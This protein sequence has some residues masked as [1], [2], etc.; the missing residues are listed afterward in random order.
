MKRVA[1]LL[2]ALFAGC[3]TPKQPVAPARAP[4]VDAVVGGVVST[5]T[6]SNMAMAIAV[7]EKKQETAQY[8]EIIENGFIDAAKEKTTTFSIDVDGAS[9]ANVRRF[10]SANL[11]PPPNAVRIEEMVNYFTYS[12]PQPADGRPLA[13]A[14]EVAGCPWEPSHRVVRIGIQGK[15]IDPWKLAPNNLVFLLD[16]S[17][18]MSPPQRLPLL[19]SAFR[20][21]VDQLRPEDTVSIVVY[22]GAAG[23]VLP[24]T[25]GSEKQTID[26]S[27][28]HLHAG[29]STAGGAGI[30][31]AYQTAEEH[32]SSSANNRVILATDGDFNVGVTD[33]KQLTN[34]IE[35]KRRK[36]I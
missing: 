17:G 5:K 13:V 30:E 33:M 9:Y 11:V 2:V 35:E 34:L 7:P 32:F 31:L 21:L 22:A 19:Q 26:A 25:P 27:L 28:D 1:I 14:T 18:S 15:T 24:P 6:V 29:G 3:A 12:Y 8:A 23:V 4:A 36:G 16:V 20:M 10:L